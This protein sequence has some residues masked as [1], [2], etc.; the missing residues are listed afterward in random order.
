[1]ARYSQTNP[2]TDS[3]TSLMEPAMYKAAIEGKTEDIKLEVNKDKLDI[4][5]SPYKNTVL[6]IAALFGK[7]ECLKNILA[8][9]PR[10]Y[11]P[12]NSKGETP[13]HIAA[14]EGH[15]EIVELLIKHANTHNYNGAAVPMLM[16]TN[17]D[18][19]TVLHEAVRNCHTKLVELFNKEAPELSQL[20]NNAEETPLYL[21]AEK[22]LADIVRQIL[23]C[24]LKP[25]ISPGYGGPYGRNALHAAVLRDSQ[26][27]VDKLLGW[28]QN[29]LKESDVC[30]WTPLHYAARF[31]YVPMVKKL[32]DKDKFVAYLAAENDDK[33]T[34]LHVATMQGH[35]EVMRMI[36]SDCPGCWEM[37]NSRGQ[38]ILHIAVKSGREA[39]MKFILRQSWLSSLINQK[40]NE[41]NT[42]LHLLVTSKCYMPEFIMHPR[43]DKNAF[44]KENLTPLD[45][46]AYSVPSGLTTAVE[47]PIERAL[48]RGGAIMG[49]RNLSGAE[50]DDPDEAVVDKD[51]KN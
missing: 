37:L 22:G 23:E 41:G 34:A 16:Q 6:H 31:G 28:K 15:D 47:G 50:M 46:L 45:V 17:E 12:L 2:T 49:R 40:D 14:R 51:C 1:M 35:L 26:D 25:N 29:L 38:N 5:V 44:N 9:C 39:V 20:S 48:T 7:T 13:L 11:D 4:I 36:I 19:D 30:G 24:Q 10:I 27:C 33:K 32:L 8:T 21:A 43:V 18:K 3:H 42:P